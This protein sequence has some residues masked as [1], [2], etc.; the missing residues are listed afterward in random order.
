MIY[1]SHGW[2]QDNEH[3]FARNDPWAV[4]SIFAV[5]PLFMITMY[6][7]YM[8]AG[9]DPAYFR[10]VNSLFLAASGLV[11]T[12][13]AGL[14]F[15]ASL[16]PPPGA[17]AFHRLAGIVVGLIFVVHPAQ[18]C[19]V[20]Y[21]IQR[22]AIMACFFYF[23]SVGLYI[24]A[25]AGRFRRRPVVY[26]LT[27]ALFL[28]GMFCKEN[29]ATAP[30]VMLLAELTLFGA[31]IKQLIRRGLTIALITGPPM[32][33]YLLVTP[34]LQGATTTHPPGIVERLTEYYSISG[35]TPLEVLLTQSRNLF[36]YLGMILVP[37]VEGVSVIKSVTIS[38]SLWS[39][40]TTAAA[41]AAVFGL[42]ALGLAL[43]RRLPIEA[44]GIL[45]FV[46]ALIPESVLIPQYLFFGNRAILPMAGVLIALAAVSLRVIGFPWA[47][48]STRTVRAAAAAI[49][50]LMVAVPAGQTVYGAM[51]WNPLQF[52][53]DAYKSLPGQD[54]DLQPA[55]YLDILTNLSASLIKAEDFKGAIDLLTRAGVSAIM[56]SDASAG[57]FDRFIASNPKKSGTALA[58]LG[59]AHQRLGDFDK[60][61][62]FYRKA[63][64]VYPKE[65]RSYNNMG[66]GL[67]QRGKVR[68]AID[69]YEKAAKANPQWGIPRNNLGSALERSGKTREA[70]EQYRK[71]VKLDPTLVS[72]HIRLGHAL[73]RSDDLESAMEH[74]KKALNLQPTS[75]DALNGVGL[76]LEKSG[77]FAGAV[78]MFHRARNYNPSSAE[79]HYNLGNALFKGG[80][81]E[82]SIG[83][84]RRAIGLKPDYLFA[85]INLGAALLNS[86][87]FA[88]AR[89]AFQEALTM[90]PKNPRILFGLGIAYEGQGKRDKAVESY[91]KVLSLNPHH[92]GA[93]KKLK[94][95]EGSESR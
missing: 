82:E 89:A 50:V 17:R 33:A 34:H 77:D 72:A 53:R 18:K 66:V 30:V 9:M 14:V 70:I 29:V 75:A 81:P 79:I 10:L 91:K 74:Y 28:A 48:F 93:E 90:D 94:S 64:T 55:A 57:S 51:R 92:A 87:R 73:R 25:R 83:L 37:W 71:A 7:N 20:L 78:E 21:I 6:L 39:P 76:T 35:L 59:H 41:V 31:G 27:G 36:S 43:V 95:M 38:R 46:I 63:V 62:T 42:V 60:A 68:E 88:Q 26:T 84:Y 22:E 4:M 3:V 23:A 69:A 5:R 2:I 40:P 45:F 85:H 47:R 15:Q 11:L 49:C 52:W 8:T 13:L 16:K 65:A 61:L 32:L 12:C 67:E 86:S 1:D 58:H 19:V 24:A 44:F 80:R 54:A 56:T